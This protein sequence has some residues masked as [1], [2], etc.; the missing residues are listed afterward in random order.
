MSDSI[1][2][3]ALCDEAKKQCVKQGLQPVQWRWSRAAF[4]AFVAEMQHLGCYGPHAPIFGNP[5]P[6]LPPG[7]LGIYEGL[8]VYSMESPA[9]FPHLA[10]ACLGAR[11]KPPGF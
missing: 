6:S 2:I 4:R 3:D 5:H 11:G 1:S 8:P 9:L 7:C 10:V